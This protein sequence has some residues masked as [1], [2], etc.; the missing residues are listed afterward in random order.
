MYLS[1]LSKKEL[2]VKC[3][4]LGILKCKSKNKNQL[5]NLLNDKKYVIKVEN[6]LTTM[7]KKEL[8]NK[9][10]ELK[11]TGY[12][13]KNKS[14]LI[15]LINSKKIIITKPELLSGNNKR[16]ETCKKVG[17]E[18]KRKGH[19]REE[20]F[21]K[22][23]NKKDIDKPIEYGAKADNTI[24]SKNPI[25]K[26]LKEKIGISN[27]N[28]S[29]KSGNNIQ[30]TLGKIPELENI[31]LSDITIEFT[32]NLFCKYLKKNNSDKPADILVYK[33]VENRKWIFFNIDDIIEYIATKCVW[34]KLDTGRIKGDFKDKSIK[35]ISQYITYE[36]RKTHKSY[37]L[38]LNGNTGKKFIKLLMDT[39]IGIR[40]YIDDFNY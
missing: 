34:R 29:N 9:C 5:V 20:D 27:F 4:E 28:V 30:F 10:E 3:S 24:D 14:Q 11:I 26:I 7:N 8:Q 22:Q 2:L 23:Y 19:K 15:E 36:Y 37:F 32:R 21:R 35:G 33:D 12:K 17:G 1:K 39:N 31:N 40:H 16:I 13:S 6:S 38:G 18:K 25:C